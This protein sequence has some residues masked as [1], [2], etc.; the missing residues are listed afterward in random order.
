MGLMDKIQRQ[1]ELHKVSKYSSRRR[2]SSSSRVPGIPPVKEIKVAYS[3]DWD[4]PQAKKA[5]EVEYAWHKAEVEQ[6]MNATIK[7]AQSSGGFASVV[8][9]SRVGRGRRPRDENDIISSSLPNTGSKEGT[10][11]TLADDEEGPELPELRGRQPSRLYA[12]P[13]SY[14]TTS[15]AAAPS[16]PAIYRYN[17]DTADT[18][19]ASQSSGATRGYVSMDA[20]PRPRAKSLGRLSS[21]ADIAAEKAKTLTRGKSM[22]G[23]KKAAADSGYGGPVR[24]S[25]EYNAMNMRRG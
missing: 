4:S 19:S 11:I 3:Y 5:H 20:H 1:V 21:V 2:S 13:E 17:T 18:S 10:L 16:R 7:R 24:S 6:N 22:W 12:D 8:T 25:E 15:A 23:K 14:H 9:M